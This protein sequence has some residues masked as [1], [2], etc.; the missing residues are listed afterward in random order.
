MGSSWR[1]TGRERNWV[2]AGLVFIL[3]FGA[4]M[5]RR[6]ALHRTPMTDLGVFSCAASAAHEGRNIYQVSDWHGWHYH[7]PPMLAI[8]FRPLAHPVPEK[9]EPLPPGGI[10][11]VAN[12]PWGY[13]VPNVGG[14]Y[15]LHREN[16]RFFLIVAAWYSISVAL[17]LFSTHALGCLVEGRQLTDGLPAEPGARRRWWGMRLIPLL[18]CLG[19]VGT[20]LSRGQ[21]DVVMLAAI[22]LGLYLAGRGVRMTAGVLLS[23]PA[24]IKLFPPLLLLYPIWRRNWR[25]AAGVLAGLA[26][27]LGALPAVALGP[28]RTAELYRTWFEVLAKPALGRGSDRSRGAE[29]TNMSATDNQS[30]LAF[31]YNWQHFGT[32]RKERPPEASTGERALTYGVGAMLIAAVLAL[33]ARRRQD[34]VVELMVRCGLLIG[35]GFLISPIVHNYYYILLM[36]LVTA[37]LADAWARKPKGGL[38]VVLAVFMACDLMARLPAIG[39]HLREWGLPMLSMVFLMAMSVTMVLRNPRQQPAAG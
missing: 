14:Y 34:S 26:L 27:A 21:V 29:L 5:E 38:P 33:F 15:G 4:L 6:T 20:E 30:L 23:I 3:A 1:L 35:L 25:M 7:Y 13:G 10:R 16:F 39:P 17:F 18:V 32:P 37:V 22:S 24:S 19:S 31:V 2:I 28:A 36:P 11:T 12:T 8:M 9:P